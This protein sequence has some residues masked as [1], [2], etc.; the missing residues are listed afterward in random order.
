M[1]RIAA[2]LMMMVLAAAAGAGELAIRGDFPEPRK[3]GQP[4]KSWNKISGAQGSLEF[5][6]AE[7]GNAVMLTADEKKTFGIYS[8]PSAAKAGDKIKVTAKVRGD[9]VTFAIFQ[10]SGKSGSS[11]QR[12]VLKSTA[13]GKDLEAVFTVTDTPKGATDRIRVCFMVENGASASITDV[14][15]FLLEE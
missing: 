4:P 13:E 15:A 3:P 7:S 6:S 2:T 8:Q 5:V 11:A 14:K 9:R 10:Y 12:K 1:K